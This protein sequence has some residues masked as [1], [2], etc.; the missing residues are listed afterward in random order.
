MICWPVIARELR[1]EARHPVN[2]WLRVL[3][4]LVFLVLPFVPVGPMIWSPS[5]QG[6]EMFRAMNYILGA[7]IW[8]VVPL[9]TADCI[10]QER[11]EGTLGL[12][13]LTPLT[14]GG[15]AVAK[16]LVHFLRAL[17]F[18]VATFPVLTIP[19]LLGGVSGLAVLQAMAAN[20]SAVFLALAAGM[21][22]SALCR[23]R[24]RSIL[25]ALGFSLLF[26]RVQAAYLAGAGSK[27]LLSLG[28][29]VVFFLGVLGVAALG[30][31]R[32]GQERPPSPELLELAEVFCKPRLWPSLF[33]RKMTRA[34]NRNPI[35]WLQQYSWSARLTKW[36]WCFG[37]VVAELMLVRDS[38]RPP[39]GWQSFFTGLFPFLAPPI[40]MVLSGPVAA[41]P[42]EQE[43][44]AFILGLG[45]ALTAAGSFHRERQTGAMELILVTP[46]RV[47][48][49][50]A[51]RLLGIASQFLPALAVLLLVWG[52]DYFYLRSFFYSL[53]AG[54]S[55]LFYWSQQLA[56][57]FV[58]A[59]AGLY[60]SLTRLHIV[61][62]WFATVTIGFL[63][64]PAMRWILDL[65]P[66]VFLSR[67]YYPEGVPVV[68]WAG[69]IFPSVLASLFWLLAH[70]N[71]VRRDFAMNL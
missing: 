13:F 38:T 52:F 21:L 27:P 53:R 22:A 11:R 7:A 70:R 43:A 48:Q 17:S 49:I 44:L 14:A 10:S 18:V 45:L 25:F 50:I 24:V 5:R 42:I 26:A 55:W 29:A 65:M 71:L 19:L 57:Y 20:L 62:A 33:H 31:H 6:L 61:T 37:I 4:A 46:L 23:E 1:A 36:G 30:L 58:L 64:L 63:L 41:G 40:A 3:G 68:A 54:E 47:N 69:T 67:L 16:G 8:L 66:R 12:L 34:L 15:I 35:G 59:M 28:A 2:Y 56:T 9:L 39:W 32:H 51:G 60:F